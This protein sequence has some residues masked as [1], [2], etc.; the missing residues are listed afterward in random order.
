MH[1]LEVLAAQEH[2]MNQMNMEFDE[3]YR[4]RDS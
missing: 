3:Y 4:R 1:Y 2:D